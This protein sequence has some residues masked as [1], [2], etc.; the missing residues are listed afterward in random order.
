M[1]SYQRPSGS[2]RTRA[3]H[4]AGVA[5]SRR[6]SM[7]SCLGLRTLCPVTMLRCTRRSWHEI[8]INSIGI[9]ELARTDVLAP[10]QHREH[11]AE[12]KQRS[13]RTG[14]IRLPYPLPVLA[15]ELAGPLLAERGEHRPQSAALDPLDHGIPV[16]VLKDVH[17]AGLPCVHV[18]PGAG[19]QLGVLFRVAGL[20]V[21]LDACEQ[22]PPPGGP[23][24]LPQD[25][26]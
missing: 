12:G 1:R 21:E 23:G 10:V 6:T 22:R 11:P 19:E 4:S 8:S 17:V 13:E 14:A 7:A 20:A 16:P 18:I 26:L 5:V 2:S 9:V 3:T 15:E 24:H 25:H